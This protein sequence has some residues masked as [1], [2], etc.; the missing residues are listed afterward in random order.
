MKIKLRKWSKLVFK[1][2]ILFLTVIFF[3]LIASYLSDISK[4]FV[5]NDEYIFLIQRTLQSLSIVLAVFM[6]FY[7]KKEFNLFKEIKVQLNINKKKFFYFCIGS[8]ILGVMLPCFLY[9]MGYMN[10]EWLIWNKL[11]LED[12]VS[13]MIAGILECFLYVASEEIIYRLA[14]FKITTKNLSSIWPLIFSTIIYTII[15]AFNNNVSFISIL[16]MALLN[17]VMM[18]IYIIYKNICICI[19]SRTILEYITSYVFSLHRYGDEVTGLIGFRYSGTSIITGGNYGIYGSILTT[20]V[21][22][23]LIV[24]MILKYKFHFNVKSLK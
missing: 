5:S 10:V 20:I 17:I 3:S 18:C 14:I 15:Y 8:A 22:L 11:F 16:N 4:I 13:I 23:I 21:F 12:I 7:F 19:F 6:F 24:S 1:L 9:L 2:A